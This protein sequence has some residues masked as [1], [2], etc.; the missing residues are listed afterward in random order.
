MAV[1]IRPMTAQEFEYFYQWSAEQYST[2]LAAES[3]IT[4][5]GAVKKAMAELS[6]MLPD[7]LHTANHQLMTVEETLRREA[8]GFI[9]TVYEVKD[10]RKQCFICDF[11]IWEPYRRNGYATAALHLTEEQAVWADCSETV[12]FVADRNATAKALY[13][14]C[15]YRLLRQSGRGAYLIKQIP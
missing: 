9:W 12:L 14:K 5:A 1:T 7:G 15:G 13:Q 3:P 8:V 2:E 4:P 6:G 11:A 10:G